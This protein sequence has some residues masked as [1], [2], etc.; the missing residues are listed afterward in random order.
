MCNRFLLLCSLIELLYCSAASVLEIRVLDEKLVHAMEIFAV[1]LNLSMNFV[2][3][4]DVSVHSLVSV[5]LI[6]YFNWFCR[7]IRHILSGLSPASCFWFL[8][9]LHRCT[10]N[11]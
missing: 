2:G 10:F 5:S 9:R 7:G 11:I 1:R 4:Y 3:E 8:I 6:N